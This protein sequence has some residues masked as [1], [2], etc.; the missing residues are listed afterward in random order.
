M[1]R[2]MKVKKCPH[3]FLNPQ[4][5]KPSVSECSKYFLPNY[6]GAS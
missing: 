4:D 3:N 5:N 2:Y 6:P 1:K